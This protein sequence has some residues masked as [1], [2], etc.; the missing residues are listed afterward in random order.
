MNETADTVD[1]SVSTH[2]K[3]LAGHD[4]PEL[5]RRF[6]ST[7]SYLALDHKVKLVHSSATKPSQASASCKA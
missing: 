2:S 3:I 5:A 4:D 1:E 7:Q 6:P